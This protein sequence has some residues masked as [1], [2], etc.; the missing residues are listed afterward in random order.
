MKISANNVQ[1]FEFEQEAFMRLA[2]SL[3]RRGLGNVWPNPAVGC[4]IVS[5]GQIVGRGW[6]MPGGRP[7]AEVVALKQAGGLARGGE[8]Y[9]TLEP[10][11]HEG[12]TG[13]C[14]EALVSAGIKKIYISTLDPDPRVNGKGVLFLKKNKISISVGLLEKEAIRLNLGFF[15]KISKGRPLVTMK[16]ASTLDGKIALG[17]GLS[18][19][20]TNE[21]ARGFSHLFRYIH[22]AVAVG[23]GTVLADN[24]ELTCRLPG[25]T[26]C[27]KPRIILDRRLRTADDS[28]LAN[29]A[30]ETPVWIVTSDTHKKQKFKKLEDKGVK[31]ILSPLSGEPKTDLIKVLKHLGKLGL[32]RLLFEPGSQLGAALLTAG[33]VDQLVVF[34]SSSIAGND[35]VGMIG[36][37]YLSEISKMPKMV[38]NYGLEIEENYLE[39]FERPE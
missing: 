30:R 8:V 26:N 13:P 27:N 18:K 9:V 19:W 24:P 2:L 36:N 22:D 3:A 7:H 38:R 14:A 34:R 12:K 28:N 35:G 33:L 16:T 32:T 20:I 17:N 11:C 21:S 37:L 5:K 39:V 15:L 23:S 25:I 6:T 31:I 4:V 10:C 29:S 1:S